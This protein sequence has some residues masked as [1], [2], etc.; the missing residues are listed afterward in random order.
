MFVMDAATARVP[1][2]VVNVVCCSP[3]M[4]IDP[5]TAIAE[6]A[7]VSDINGVCSSLETFWMTWKP[8]NV[9]SRKTKAIDQRSSGCISGSYVGDDCMGSDLE[10]PTAG[11]V[12]VGKSAAAMLI[13]SPDGL[14]CA[15]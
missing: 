3:A 13:E 12:R 8:T 4:M 1:R 7:F 2:T 14:F 11:F 9:A 6:M 5:T 15:A 10:F